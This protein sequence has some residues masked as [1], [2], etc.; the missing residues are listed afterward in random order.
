VQHRS[1]REILGELARLE[2]EIQAEMRELEGML[3]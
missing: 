3:G 1:P 2:G